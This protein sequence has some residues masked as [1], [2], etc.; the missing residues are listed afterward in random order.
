MS[1]IVSLVF[2]V[3]LLASCSPEAQPQPQPQAQPSESAVTHDDPL[4][5]IGQ[6]RRILAVGDSLFAGY[7]L[8]PGESYPAKLEAALRGRGINVRITNAGVS[9][10]TSAAGAQ[11]LG[12]VLDSQT[13]PP[14]LV[15][16][17]FGGNDILRALPP[18][19]TRQNLDA[20]LTETRRRG[21]KVL[22]MGMMAPPN[23]G[24]DYRS[25][26]DPIYPALAKKHGAGLVPFFLSA[27]MDKPDLVQ[28][29]HLHPTARGVEEI[30][31]ATTAQV[32]AALPPAPVS[33]AV[34]PPRR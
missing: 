1:R 34:P 28:A 7:G 24:A 2:A 6:E 31:A 8:N 32:A 26:F 22:V 21:L 18:E 23:L 20:M 27:V 16:I 5:V 13:A 14:D 12:F 3:M 29:D 25:K 30:V 9:G 10:D 17:E 19:Q 4:P 11:R 33:R 15:I